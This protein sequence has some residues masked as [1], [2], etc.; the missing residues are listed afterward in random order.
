MVSQI[1]GRLVCLG[2]LGLNGAPLIAFQRHSVAGKVWEV[3]RH[4]AVVTVVGDVASSIRVF[5]RDL[6]N[7]R[8]NGG[9]G[10]RSPLQGGSLHYDLP[11]DINKP[12]TRC[13]VERR[14]E[15]IEFVIGGGRGESFVLIEVFDSLDLYLVH[16]VRRPA[17]FFDEVA[18]ESP[19]KVICV[20][21]GDGVGGPLE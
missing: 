6:E 14:E 10:G 7:M 12:I 21:G 4:V 9:M 18:L 13:G 5:R 20:L 1:L 3:S 2:E 11:S 16:H 17:V 15:L 8:K 19:E